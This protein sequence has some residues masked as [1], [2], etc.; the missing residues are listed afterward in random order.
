MIYILAERKYFINI[1]KED[2]KFDDVEYDTYVEVEEALALIRD[3][4]ALEIQHYDKPLYHGDY[5]ITK[6]RKKVLQ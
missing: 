2:R 4:A 6:K 3:N 5:N 1:I